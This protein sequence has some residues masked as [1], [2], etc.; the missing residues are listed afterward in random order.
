[1]VSMNIT[2]EDVVAG[3]GMVRQMVE[4]QE[5]QAMDGGSSSIS[6]A[7]DAYAG[8][9]P[10]RGRAGAPGAPSAFAPS[11]LSVGELARVRSDLRR[12]NRA[13]GLSTSISDSAAELSTRLHKQGP[14]LSLI[15]I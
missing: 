10:P 11:E 5:M 4:A 15:H 2:L 14:H 7:P 12:I 6:P 9:S 13:V 8:R 1:M 3:R